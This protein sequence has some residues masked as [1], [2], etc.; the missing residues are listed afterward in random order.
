MRQRIAIVGM[1]ISGLVA[2]HRLHEAHDIT[3]YEAN[4]YIGGHTHTIEV[5]RD[6]RVWPVDTGFI[7]FNERNYVNFIALLDELGVSSHPTTMSFSVRCDTANLEY[8]GTSLEKLFVQRRNM[9]RPSF[10]RMVRDI[11]RFYRESRELLE[12]HDDTTTLGEYLNLNG[13]SREF[14]D[15]HIIPMGSAIWSADPVDMLTFP[16]TTF[17]RFFDHHGFLDLK[18]RPQ[19]RVVDGGS[20]AYVKRLTIPFRHRIRL[21][22]PVRS[23]ARTGD[24]IW[25]AASDDTVEKYDAVFIACHSDQALRMLEAPTPS[26]QDILGA[27]PYAEN[28]VVLHTDTSLLP[29]RKRAW[30]SWN[31]LLPGDGRSGATVTYNQNILQGLDAPETFCVSLNQTERIDPARVIQSFTYHHP[32]YTVGTVAAQRRKDEISGQENTY[33]CGAYWGFGFHEDGVNSAIDAVNAFEENLA[34]SAAYTKAG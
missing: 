34:C 11:V 32:Q 10:H 25:I 21:N 15:H 24:E 28:P 7:V 1:G 6:G 9:L 5:E 17:V 22:T 14:T 31:Y 12:G 30:A 27:I 33:Y 19:W 4:D 8:N 26:E 18:D 16:A 20:H 13:Y 2:A 23:I 3:V 29:K